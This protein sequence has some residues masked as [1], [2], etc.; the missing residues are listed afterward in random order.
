LAQPQTSR[1]AILASGSG[2]NAEKIISYFQD[3]PSIEV[4]LVL[5]NSQEAH[6]LDRA[7]RLG[8]PSR[9]F[10]K[11]EFRETTAVVDW[12]KSDDVTHLVLAGFLWLIPPHMIRAFPDRIIN[13]HPS[14][15]PRHGGKGMYGMKVHEAVKEAGDALAGI[16][17]HLI[18]ERYDEGR[19]LFQT[20]C[21]V[22]LSDSPSHIAEK[23]HQLEY[24][25]YPRVIEQWITGQP[26]RSSLT[27]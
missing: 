5:S 16:T 6:V 27:K 13:I 11:T 1:I 26:I 23:V 25:S 22:D 4:A 21:P 19:I 10:T 9:V 20:S 12:L 14:L 8:I 3:H 2:S 24:T 7:A 15:L 18:N 17:I